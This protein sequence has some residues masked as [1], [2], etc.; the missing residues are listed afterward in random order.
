METPLHPKVKE[1]HANN[2]AWNEYVIE[3]LG[4]RIEKRKG[5]DYRSITV[6]AGSFK[7]FETYDVN[8]NATINARMHRALRRYLEEY[9]A[10]FLKNPKMPHN[11]RF[12]P[13]P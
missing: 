7:I 9:L 6:Y 13:P 5:V 4:L 8:V 2:V 12:N 11:D 1:N 3:N 10:Y